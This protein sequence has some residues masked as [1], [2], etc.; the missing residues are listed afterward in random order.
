MTKTELRE[1]GLK[2]TGP[3]LKILALLELSSARHLSAEELYSLLKVAGENVGLAT[4][5]RV[6]TQFCDAGLVKRHHFE[7]DS[8][9]YELDQGEHHDHLVCVQC[10]RVTEFLDEEIESR[11]VTIANERGFEI[12]DHVMTIYGVCRECQ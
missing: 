12:T 3:R 6:L 1:K 2:V 5:Y 7:G 9:V 4:V 11:Q 10:N 8:A